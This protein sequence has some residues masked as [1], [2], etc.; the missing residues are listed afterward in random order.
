MRATC[1]FALAGLT[2][3]VATPVAAADTPSTASGLAYYKN[4]TTLSGVA[5]RYHL[6]VAEIAKLNGIKDPNR[7]RASGLVLPD[8][9]S[10]KQL[11]RY[12]PWVPAKAR[13][14]CAATVW[15]LSPA[16]ET[17]CAEAF[18]GNGPSGA[19]ACSCKDGNGGTHIA[20]RSAAG[21]T[22]KL[23]RTPTAWNSHD[24]DS[25]EIASMDLDGDGKLETL[26]SWLKSVGNGIAAESRTLVVLAESGHELLRYDSGHFTAINAGVRVGG[27]CHLAS[28]KYE[29]ATHPLRGD[30]LYLMER[31]FDPFA[32]RMDAELIGRRFSDTT[33]VVVPLDPLLG[34]V[35]TREPGTITQALR[36]SDGDFAGVQFRVSRTS[37]TVK[38]DADQDFYLGDAGAGRVFPNELI[39]SG[40]AG[41][42]APL[43]T[44]SSRWYSNTQV[45]WLEP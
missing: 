28:S 24:K 1:S 42:A 5:A 19:Q 43:K 3:L 18:C 10:T 44:Y 27:Q 29:W 36:N 20:V 26:V 40:L 37:Q 34:S 15:A 35:S 45:L 39:F 41:R 17:G 16:T 32:M 31:T 6:S 38:L 7:F 2:A 14:A 9:P 21:T 33:R 12:V 13:M 23:A 4:P 22:V 11:P 8:I 25:F 30:A